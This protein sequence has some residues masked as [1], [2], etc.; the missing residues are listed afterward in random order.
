MRDLVRLYES[1]LVFTRLR[2]RAEAELLP[3]MSALGALLRG[4][5][6]AG[7]LEPA[8]IQSAADHLHRLTDDWRA[9]LDDMRRDPTLCRA[10][11]AF[12]QDDPIALRLLLPEVFA[13]HVP[14]PA[15]AHVLYYAVPLA[16][17][18]RRPG[19]R[20]FLAAAEA[21]ERIVACRDGVAPDP[22]RDWWDISLGFIPLADDPVSL[23]TP[24]TLAFTLTAERHALFSLVGESSMRLYAR[25]LRAP[26]DVVVAL[27]A[28]DDWWEAAG[29][30]YETFREQLTASLRDRDIAVAT[31]P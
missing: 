14:A 26:F 25:A 1:A 7:T 4:D 22:G 27:D 6:R 11:R 17:S 8:A 20:P 29:D 5:L 23:D 13:G 2:E 10:V 24:I 28:R 21:A 30:S 9:K 3:Q 12:E 19:G 18:H 31:I 16:A 15:A